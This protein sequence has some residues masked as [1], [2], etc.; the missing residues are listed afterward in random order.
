MTL[1]LLNLLAKFRANENVE[2]PIAHF[3]TKTPW[4]AP[5]AYLHIVY[6]AASRSLVDQ[7]ASELRFP[8]AMREFYDL[9]NGGWFFNGGFSIYGCVEEG[10]LLDRSNRFALPPFNIRDLNFSIRGV[11]GNLVAVGTY[12][13][14]GSVVCVHR[15]TGQTVC[16]VGTSIREERMRWNSLEQWIHQE[17]ERIGFLF[18][19]N[20]RLL[21]GKENILPSRTV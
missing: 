17:I 9:W 4:V 10:M 13:Y 14:D 18:D 11:S 15:E 7:V 12:R 1:D 6:K 16:F 3:L 5:E 20:G 2:T 21:V 19:E 8:S